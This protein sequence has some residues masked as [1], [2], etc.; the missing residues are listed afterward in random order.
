L[1]REVREEFGVDI[2]SKKLLASLETLVEQENGPDV[3]INSYLYKVGTKGSPDPKR[4]DEHSDHRW[5]TIS[6]LKQIATKI[7]NDF[8]GM[9]EFGNYL[10]DYGKYRA[11][12]CEVAY[13]LLSPGPL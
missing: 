2:E 13:E 7:A 11:V 6:D 12:A 10:G 8:H 4:S 5:A 3:T 9:D 1:K